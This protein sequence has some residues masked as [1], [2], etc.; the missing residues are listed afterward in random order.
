MRL[1]IPKGLL[2][3]TSTNYPF[4]EYFATNSIL[5][6]LP[7]F[8]LIN[9]N[10][11]SGSELIA[12]VLRHHNRGTILGTKSLGQGLVHSLRKVPRFETYII[13]Y[14]TSFLYLP[15]GNKFHGPGITPDIW[16]GDGTNEF[17]K[18]FNPNS[19][20]TDNTSDGTKPNHSK[21]QLDFSKIGQ[22]VETNGSAK[23]N[24]QSDLK[25]GLTPDYQL[26]HSI[27]VFSGLL[28]TKD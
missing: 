24:I 28:A 6:D 23:Q 5:T 22:W 2:Y 25:K 15:D 3:S 16:I 27:D 17:P 18:F 19:Y 21:S 12:G 14:P 4:N 9:E 11:G 26:L 10:T 8:V 7:L 13:K 20:T 1:F